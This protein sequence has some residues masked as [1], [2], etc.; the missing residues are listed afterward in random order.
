[1]RNGSIHLLLLLLDWWLSLRGRI[2]IRG[3]RLF[4]ILL[5]LRSAS[6]SRWLI[7]RLLVD[8][9]LTHIEI[10]LLL[11]LFLSLGSLDWLKNIL[12]QVRVRV[13]LFAYSFVRL[14]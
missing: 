8:N 4:G 13:T 9:E 7:L 10:I 5:V 12:R 6:L 3:A 11:N 2:F 1:M 14:G